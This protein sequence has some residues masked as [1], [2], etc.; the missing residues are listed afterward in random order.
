VAKEVA[1]VGDQEAAMEV[2]AAAHEVAP[3][4]VVERELDL[5]K[6]ASLV[7]PLL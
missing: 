6:A 4:V 5:L 7:A 1:M 2:A 3:K